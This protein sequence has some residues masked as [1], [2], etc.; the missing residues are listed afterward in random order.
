MPQDNVANYTPGGSFYF[1]RL[2]DEG[3]VKISFR[4]GHK[5][6]FY[7]VKPSKWEDLIAS[8]SWDGYNGDSKDK[9]TALHRGD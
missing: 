6:Y 7:F 9:A 1:K 4:D 8:I 5:E 3:T 2:N